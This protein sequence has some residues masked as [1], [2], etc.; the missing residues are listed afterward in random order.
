M[1]QARAVMF[2]FT[3]ILTSFICGYQNNNAAGLPWQGL[4]VLTSIA[5]AWVQSL[6]WDLRSYMLRDMV[7]QKK[8]S[9]FFLHFPSYSF[10]SELEG[11]DCVTLL[12][13]PRTC[14]IVITVL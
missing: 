2:Q 3:F 6:V 8:S 14:Y 5:G 1:K 10:C 4:I 12:F 11:R 9:F 7:N 13:I